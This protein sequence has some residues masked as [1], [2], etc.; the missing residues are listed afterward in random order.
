MNQIVKSSNIRVPKPLD[1]HHA[2]CTE[3]ADLI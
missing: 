2:E 1:A 3:K